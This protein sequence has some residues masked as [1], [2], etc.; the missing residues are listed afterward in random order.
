MSNDTYDSKAQDAQ[1]AEISISVDDGTTWIQVKEVNSID[2]IGGGSASVKDVTHLNS[3]AKEKR[4]GLKD[5]GQVSLG[6]NYIEDD[7]G[8][9]AMQSARNES[10]KVK[11]K[12]ELDN[13]KG[14]NGSNWIFNA[15][16]QTFKIGNISN[17][18]T[19]SFDSSLEITGSVDFKGAE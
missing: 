5:E 16:I 12:I 2:G 10:T 18:Q 3:A 8:Q 14:T 1:G 13:S 11:I 9:I 17:D 19:V 6:G 15:F 4:L 7:L